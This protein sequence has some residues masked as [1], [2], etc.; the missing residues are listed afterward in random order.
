MINNSPKYRILVSGLAYDE[1]KSGISD[2]MNNVIPLLAEEHKVDLLI[3]EDDIERFPVKTENLNFIPVAEKLRRPVYSMVWHLFIFPYRFDFSPYDFIFLPAGN[4]RVMAKYPIPTIVT[5]HDLSQF[6]IP[7]KYDAFRMFYIKKLI[8]FFVKKAD[9]ILAISKNTRDDLIKFY[10]I[11][12]DKITVNYNGYNRQRYKPAEKKFNKPLGIQK[13]YL[14][15]LSRLEHP[16][17]NHLRLIMA[18][19]KLPEE[20]RE[21]Y[22]LVLPGKAWSGS[23]EIFDYL[24]TSPDQ[25]RIH[26]PGFVDSSLLPELYQQC[27]LYIFPSLYEGFG[28]PLIEAMASGVPVICSNTSSLPEIGGEAVALFDP[29]SIE[30]I[31]DTILRVISSNVMQ[32]AM[33]E[34]GFM[35]VNKFSWKKHVIQ[36]VKSYEEIVSSEG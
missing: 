33:I 18:Y 25:Q 36:I 19:E 21:R 12:P 4:R 20:F 30:S 9:K 7:A 8:P 28:I 26:L 5:F 13:K 34:N 35:Q 27:S 3:L 31:R 15:Y 2:Y 22:D 24:K 10:K 16:G 17:K 6:H 11:N 29:Y 14:L 32:N 1:G 23:N